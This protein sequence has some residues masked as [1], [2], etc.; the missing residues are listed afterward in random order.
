VTQ[1]GF[2]LPIS[3][4]PR[5]SRERLRA[6]HRQLRTAIVEGR[7][8]P[9]LRLPPTRMLAAEYGVSRNT[10]VAAYDLLLSEGYLTSRRGAG[11]YVADV[12]PKPPARRTAP[13]AKSGAD[14]RLNALWLQPAM[15]FD[16]ERVATRFH[17][18]V[19]VPDISRFP[20]DVWRRLSARA[21]RRLPKVSADYDSPH[22]RPALR[23]AIARHVSFARA[24]ACDPDDVTVTAGAQQAFDLLAR[25]LVVPK[26]T[27][28]ALENP[29]YPPLR[30][31]FAA[32][33]ARIAAVPVDEQ[34]LIVE[35]LPAQAKIVCVTPSHQF[36]LGAVMSASR[37]AALLEFAQ[38][39]G[40]VVIEDDYDAEFRFSDRPL[41]ALQTLDR[42]ESVFYV[43]TFSKSPV[44]VAAPRFR[45]RSAVGARCTRCS[46]AGCG[47]ALCFALAGNARRIHRGRTSR[48]ARAAHARGV[49]RSSTSPPRRLAQRLFRMVAA[50]ACGGGLAP[51]G[52]GAASAR[53]RSP[54]RAGTKA[55]RR[56]LFAAAVRA[57]TGGKNPQGL[58]FGYGALD[59]RGIAEGLARL[60]K[61]VQ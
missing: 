16:A 7:L 47:R 44:P 38:R 22:G 27:V 18:N 30:A 11:T 14:R 54:G 6:L 9:G 40:A 25:I 28:V 52:I 21:L 24:V 45:R 39:Q 15:P 13:A 60:R 8:Q 4:P 48:A 2:E 49:R 23:A 55:R 53:Y 42:S 36:P 31:A 3:I 10:A 32:A 12:L 41:D 33:G 34:G 59:E 57:R 1:S 50:G 5:K 26:R 56:H 20:V 43:G 35:R 51:D 46:Q 37:R 17:F 61:L 58:A 29:G 19:G